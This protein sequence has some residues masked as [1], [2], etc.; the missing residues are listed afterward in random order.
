MSITD[1]LKMWKILWYVDVLFMR[2]VVSPSPQL[3]WKNSKKGH[4]TI[5]QQETQRGASC[6]TSMKTDTSIL[7]GQ[8]NER[9]LVKDST[10]VSVPIIGMP[11]RWVSNSL[12]MKRRTKI[13]G[14]EKIMGERVKG[15]AKGIKDR[16]VKSIGYL[17]RPCSFKFVE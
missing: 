16:F 10:R 2:C 6:I 4:Y 8:I 3:Y 13:H 17:S 5:I 12:E 11:T 14:F 9:S 15:K 1:L 7:L